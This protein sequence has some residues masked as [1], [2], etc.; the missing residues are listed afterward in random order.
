MSII[1]NGITKDDVRYL[2]SIE[3][4]RYLCTT[5]WRLVRVLKLF[6]SNR[7]CEGCGKSYRKLHIHHLSYDHLAR[8]YM[9]LDD[10]QALCEGCHNKQHQ[11]EIITELLTKLLENKKPSKPWQPVENDNYNPH[12]LIGVGM[13]VE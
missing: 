10:L 4:E 12:S 9:Y 1:K 3:Y 5:Y 7:T 13:G 6:A 2:R 8:E 11:P